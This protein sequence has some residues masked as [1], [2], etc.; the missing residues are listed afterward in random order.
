MGTGNIHWLQEHRP[1][2]LCRAFW[3]YV[4]DD[5]NAEQD[6]GPWELWPDWLL[7]VSWREHNYVA[8]PFS[9]LRNYLMRCRCRWRGHPC[10]PVFYNPGGYEPDGSC[11]DCGEDIL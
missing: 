4:L 2:W 7:W 11:R 10:G 6:T 1:F 5:S 9:R 8:N 3:V